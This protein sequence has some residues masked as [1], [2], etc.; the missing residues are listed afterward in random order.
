LS[1]PRI[2][3]LVKQVPQF[4]NMTLGS[5]GRLRREGVALE[6]N[7]YCRRAVAMAVELAAASEGESVVVTMGPPS[8]EDCLREAIACGAGRGVLLTDRAFAG[9]DTLAT[10]AALRRL[11]DRLGGFDLVLVGKN[12]VDADTGQVGPELAQMLGWVFAGPCR[13]LDVDFE[14]ATFR[15]RCETDDGHRDV[16]GSLPAVLSCAERLV[17]P[18]KAPQEE[19]DAVAAELLSTLTTAELGEGPWGADASPTS[20]GVTRSLGVVRDP[21]VLAGAADVAVGEA[22]RVLRRRGAFDAAARDG[23]VSDEPGEFGAGP[24]GEGEVWALVEPRRRRLSVEL[25]EEAVRLAGHLGVGARVV[26]MGPGLES[27][28]VGVCGL[29]FLDADP[30]AGDEDYAR[31]LAVLVAQQRPWGLIAPSTSRGREVAS[32]VAASA[33]YGLT[34]D[35]VELE[36]GR[37][38]GLVAWKPAFGGALVAAVV[39]SSQVQIAT[40]RPGVLPATAPIAAALPEVTTVPVPSDGRIR[41]VAESI[42][43]DCEALSSAR[44]VVGVG[45]GVDPEEY[46][47]LEPLL[48]ALGAHLAAT[49]KVT[50]RG[51]LPRSRQIGITGL[52]VAPRLYVSIGAS[53]KF[54]HSSGFRAAHSVL[55]VNSDPKAPVFDHCDVGIVGDWHEVVPLLVAA[56]SGGAAGT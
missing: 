41:V 27:V 23:S 29:T 5:D 30:T 7:P 33:G 31:E 40:V 11:L 49:R 12:S 10:A 19:R 4:E 24:Q 16:E 39:S 51:W 17:A 21:E 28:P 14:S 6:M 9:S 38:G 43:D 35:A 25:A 1:P 36:V 45:I 18:A 13:E 48:D 55:A 42:E 54:N 50:D 32:R 47:A 44:A 15:A 52:S 46:T 56:V 20:V 53:G 8:A 34:G 37:S 26:A 2:A 3:A 22:V